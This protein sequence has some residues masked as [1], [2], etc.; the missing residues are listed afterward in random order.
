MVIIVIYA[1]D[2]V[3][4][5]VN[6]WEAERFKEELKDRLKKFNLE[7]HAEKT[8]LI[9]FGRYAEHNRA[10][11]GLGK[12][13]TFNFLGFTHI[14]TWNVR[15]MFT[16]LRQTMRKRMQ[17]KLKE[18]TKELKRRMH[19]PIPEQGQWLRQV[20]L[21]HYQYYGVPQNSRQMSSFRHQ[22]GI[23]WKRELGRRSQNGAITWERM[24]RLIIRWIPL[25]RI[26]HPNPGQRIGVTT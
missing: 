7:L 16:V 22:V 11:R 2:F 23:I 26:C 15:N 4:G 25:H 12:P 24:R 1:D 6:G 17:T 19:D 3:I 9:E 20:L 5:F 14:C 10:E 21:G 8:R 13:E 18:I